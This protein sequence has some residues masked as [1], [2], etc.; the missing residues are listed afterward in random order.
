MITD[1]DIDGFRIDTVK[2]VND[3]FWEAFVTE[4]DAHA[5]AEGKADFF[6]FGEVF[7]GD[8]GFLSRFTT[9]LDLPGVLDFG[10]HGAALGFAASSNAATGLQ[11]FFAGDDWFTDE[12]SSA[13]GLPNFIGNHDV[14]SVRLLHRSGELRSIRLRAGRPRRTRIRADVHQPGDAGHLLRRRAGLRRRRWRPGRPPGHVPSQVGSYND[15]DLIGTA[16]TTADDNFDT[17]HPLY[18]TLSDLS[19]LRDAHGALQTGAQ[20]ER[21]AA[22]SV[23]AFSRIDGTEYL[24]VLNNA[25]TETSAS[26]DVSTVGT[27]T[28]VWPGSE[29]LTSDGSVD[30]TVPALSARVFAAD[31]PV[32][33]PASGPGVAATGPTGEVTGRVPVTADV[34]G[35]DY[36]EVTFLVSVDG[37]GYEPLGTDDNAP[38]R[39]FH[40]VSELAVGTALT[41]KAIVS[42]LAGGLASDTTTAV[43]GEEV[44]PPPPSGDA[45]YAIIHYQRGDGDYGDHTTGDFNDF[46]GLHLWGDAIAPSEVTDWPNPKPFLGEDEYGRFAWI[47]LQDSTQPVNFIVHR[48]DTKDGTDADRS[49]DPGVNPE[50]WLKQ[51]DGNFYTSQ[52]AAQGYVTIHYQRPD[53]DYGDPTSSDFNDFWGLHLWGDAIDPS[54]GT[55]WASPKKPTGFDDFGAYWDILVQDVS[56]PVNYIIHR[57]D[58]KDRD[59]DQSMTPAADASIFVV[60]GDGADYRSRGAAEDFATI[61]YHRPGGDYG[62]YTSTDFNDFW[63]LHIWEGAASPN[64]AWQQPVKPVGFDTFG[65]IFEI[66]VI[67]GAPQLAYIIHR[68]DTKDPGPDQFL[69]FAV[70]G[71]EVW[72]LQGADPEAPYILPLIGGGVVSRGD[73]GQQQAYWVDTDTVVWD[74]EATEANLCWSA[75]AAITL[76]DAGIDGADDCLR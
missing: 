23:Y 43:V 16:A 26:F 75:T 9:E 32:P 11:G 56:Q 8:P 53:G 21:Y 48:G 76:S 31:V 47:E 7:D 72:Q 10:F 27:F 5:A 46:W 67:D 34:D 12:D 36:S 37:G 58:T 54:E 28:E 71:Y 15:D 62:D 18:Q 39:V 66:P 52:A 64:P 38:Y 42:D 68:G 14:G 60:A 44:T 33:A 2:H 30:V 63:G 55:E 35:P 59:S 57:G 61:H 49:F 13:H 17:T 4:I 74:V 69:E 45:R 22:G 6:Y 3:E 40:D 65:P 73:L 24:V 70:Y 20:I 29:T 51:D 50:I 25:E 1:F 41:Y 19:A